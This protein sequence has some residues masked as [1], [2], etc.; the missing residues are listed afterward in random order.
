MRDKDF[1][2][3]NRPDK[4]KKT[5]VTILHFTKTLEVER[6]VIDEES[7]A[8]HADGPEA[9]RKCIYIMQVLI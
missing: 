4:L 5:Y 3:R 9:H 7:G 6:N 2:S 8:L 1:K